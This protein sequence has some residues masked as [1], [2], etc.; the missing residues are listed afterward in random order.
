MNVTIATTTLDNWQWPGST[1]QLRIYALE[2][3][4]TSDGA[5]LTGANQPGAWWR[6]VPCTVSTRTD[7]GQTIRTLTIPTIPLP[8]TTDSDRPDVRYFAAFWVDG[9][10]VEP[11]GGFTAFK[12][13]D[14]SSQTWA[15]IRA[16]NN[17]GSI[18]PEA[19]WQD[20]VLDLIASLTTPD[21][22]VSTKGVVKLS[23]A[24]ASASNP[25]AVG[26]NDPRMSPATTSQ[27]G[28]MSATDKLIFNKYTFTQLT[29]ATTWVI[30]HNLGTLYPDVKVVDSADT[31]VFGDILFQNTNQLT[32]TFSAGFSGK[33]IIG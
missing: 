14:V 9:Y 19:D 25:I 33:A 7:G 1:A 15:S 27:D 24:P 23:V 28:L 16:Y 30:T 2:T 32:I 22:S 13:P 20:Q 4:K 29:P 11:W 18:E 8:S 3:F 5:I 10:L 6:D 21:A 26:T 12:V 31:Q 17:L